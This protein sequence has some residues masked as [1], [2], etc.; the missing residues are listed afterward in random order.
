MRVTHS[1][2]FLISHRSAFFLR[3]AP[4][5]PLLSFVLEWLGF[6]SPVTNPRWASD[7]MRCDGF[8]FTDGLTSQTHRFIA[9]GHDS[10]YPSFRSQGLNYW[11]FPFFSCVSKEI[12]MPVLSRRRFFPLLIS[13]PSHVS[14][15]YCFADHFFLLRHL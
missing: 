9:S 2:F 5:L 12:C 14:T 10:V 11:Y 4:N 15:P 1:S 6:S 7:H 3:H 13:P 8:F